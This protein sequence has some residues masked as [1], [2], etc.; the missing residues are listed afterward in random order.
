MLLRRAQKHKH[1][2]CLLSVVVKGSHRATER[3]KH[4]LHNPVP[5][6]AGGNSEKCEEGHA[7]VVEGGVATQPLTWVF[8]RT[9]CKKGGET[10]E[11]ALEVAGGGGGGQ[12]RGGR[13]A[14]VDQNT[15]SKLTSLMYV[16]QQR[17]MH[18]T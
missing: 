1:T 13:E 16:T 10:K 17:I 5:V 6:V 18:I 14:C 11:R 15:D 7:E 2:I 12:G 8:V 9:L 4:N 3:K